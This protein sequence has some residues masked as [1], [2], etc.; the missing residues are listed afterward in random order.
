[1]WPSWP[2]PLAQTIFWPNEI[3][4]DNEYGMFMCLAQKKYL[5]KKDIEKKAG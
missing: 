4:K 2:Y 3:L 1:M 5:F